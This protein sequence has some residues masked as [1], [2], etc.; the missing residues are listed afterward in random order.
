MDLQRHATEE[1]ISSSDL[2][3]IYTEVH[4]LG[5]VLEMFTIFI[6]LLYTTQ[7]LA[8]IILNVVSLSATVMHLGPK[9]KKL[10]FRVTQPYLM[11]TGRP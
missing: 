8:Q 1:V 3:V 4:K 5:S 9:R 11:L 2:T 7:D 10:V 6:V